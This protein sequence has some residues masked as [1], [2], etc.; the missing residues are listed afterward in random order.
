M[1][2]L[3]P[4]GFIM[5]ENVLR[6]ESKK[7]GKDNFPYSVYH[8]LIP[9][10]LK[11]FPLHWHDEMEITF[12]RKGRADFSI[13]SRH[14]VAGEGDI[15]I[16]NPRHPHCVEQYQDS[17]ADFFSIL[18]DPELLNSSALDAENVQKITD[19]KNGSG[20]FPEFT[21]KGESL[22]QDLLPFLKP[23]IEMRHQS[24]GDFQMGVIG[25]LYM[26]FQT[27]SR[28]QMKA[29]RT[30]SEYRTDF[31]KIRPAL[32]AVINHYEQK[33]SIRSAARDCC[34]SESHF[35]KLFKKTT[36]K[37]FNEYLVEHRIRAAAK[38][39]RETSDRI[40]D[41]AGSCGFGNQSYFTRMFV[42]HY[43]MTPGEYR[44]QHSGKAS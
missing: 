16:A 6:H 42:R 39:L 33:I 10:Y 34:L 41:I 2:L 28:Y 31:S 35:M 24:Y 15:L 37:S 9:L 40:V 14:F 13:C 1:T 36:S 22:N 12:I 32:D 26:L 19:L 18:F 11:S 23:L 44:R 43:A 38:M 27:L 3:L 5:N 29:D 30:V 17:E 21:G 25:C 4:K 20:I 8:S 7:H